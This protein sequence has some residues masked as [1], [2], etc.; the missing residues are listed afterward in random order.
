MNFIHIP[1]LR[2]SARIAW[3]IQQD[4]VNTHKHA[5]VHS[6]REVGG[7]GERERKQ[8][9]HPTRT[10]KTTNT[11]TKKTSPK[12]QLRIYIKTSWVLYQL[13]TTEK[14][15][16]GRDRGG[17]SSCYHEIPVTTLRKSGFSWVMFWEVETIMPLESLV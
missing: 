9:N 8:T 17:L 12:F 4:T 6:E 14:L 3:T 16:L 1:L 2:A 10:I 13:G 15:S 11:K 7:E 5:H